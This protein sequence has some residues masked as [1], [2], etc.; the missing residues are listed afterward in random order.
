MHVPHIPTKRNIYLQ[1]S[2]YRT[3]KYAISIRVSKNC[4]KPLQKI[5]NIGWPPIHKTLPK[6]KTAENS[7]VKCRSLAGENPCTTPRTRDKRNLF[8]RTPC[9]KRKD[10]AAT[11]H[12]TGHAS[13]SKNRRGLPAGSV[14]WGG[15]DN[16]TLLD[17]AAPLLT[18]GLKRA[19]WACCVFMRRAPRQL[20]NLYFPTWEWI[21]ER[22]LPHEHMA[23]QHSGPHWS[24]CVSG[25]D[26]NAKLVR[27][28]G[29]APVNIEV[30]PGNTAVVCTPIICKAHVHVPFRVGSRRTAAG[31][32][33]L[34][35]C[36]VSSHVFLDKILGLGFDVLVHF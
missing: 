20:F 4:S 33:S 7:L 19:N 36:P 30:F 26:G 35:H 18:H 9:V 1:Q 3:L 28:S 13:C 17:K 5:D 21:C 2:N 31:V 10:F 11:R 23:P 12:I 15:G 6:H 29:L 22:H 34:V 24:P 16:K 8:W 25:I 27:K 32:G 14:V